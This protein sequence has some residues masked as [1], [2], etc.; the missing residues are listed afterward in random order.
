MR[1]VVAVINGHREGSLLI[2]TIRSMMLAEDHARAA[3][4]DCGVCL[5]LD[6]PDSETSDVIDEWRRPDWQVE[7]SDVADLGLARNEAVHRAQESKY[8]AFLDGDD[9]CSR[10]WLTGSVQHA[11]AYLDRPVIWHPAANFVF[12]RG[13]TYLYLHRDMDDPE[14]LLSYLVLDNYWTALSFGERAIYRDH[15]YSPNRLK[16]G[17]G[18]EDWT[19]NASTISAGVKHKIVPDTAHFIRRKRNSLLGDT[20]VAGAMPYLGPLQDLILVDANSAEDV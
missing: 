20:K 17:W 18:Y 10:N 13:D 1:D 9:L 4:I 14:F 12:G 5:L 6:N 11:N 2:P 7:V 19:W 15:P 3:G 8:L 16:E